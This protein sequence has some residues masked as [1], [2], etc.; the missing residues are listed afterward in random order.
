M[1][2]DTTLAWSRSQRRQGI[3]VEHPGQ[4]RTAAPSSGDFLGKQL[5]TAGR[6]QIGSSH[7]ERIALFIYAIVRDATSRSV[8]FNTE[9][10]END[11][12]KNHMVFS[13]QALQL[14]LVYPS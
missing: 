5:D 8:I 1:G 14:Q 2:H 6:V 3:G 11:F 12:K 13:A 7:K 9:N 10:I 4:R